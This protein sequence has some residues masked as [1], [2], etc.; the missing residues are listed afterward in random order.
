MF[1]CGSNRNLRGA[2]KNTCP[3]T[4][5]DRSRVQLKLER[6]MATGAKNVSISPLKGME[7]DRAGAQDF[8]RAVSTREC[9][10]EAL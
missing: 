1:Y 9:Y 3:N 2:I 5:F 6:T 10:L 4:N 8:E 7:G